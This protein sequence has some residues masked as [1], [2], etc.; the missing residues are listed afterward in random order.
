MVLGY[1]PLH[2]WFLSPTSASESKVGF[3][4]ANSVPWARLSLEVGTTGL[5]LETSPLGSVDS[6]PLHGHSHRGSPGKNA[7]KHTDSSW[8][9]LLHTY[10]SQEWVLSWSLIL[11]ACMHSFIHSFIHSFMDTSNTTT[12]KR[13]WHLTRTVRISSIYPPVQ[14]LP[15]QLALANNLAKIKNN[16]ENKWQE[17]LNKN[18]K[19]I[20]RSQLG[21]GKP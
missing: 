10:V 7:Y 17:K 14:Y 9:N 1:L 18:K 15:T 13:G 8:E 5:L 6:V 21:E 11:F 4:A 19:P 2:G 3:M 20:K 12:F 16:D